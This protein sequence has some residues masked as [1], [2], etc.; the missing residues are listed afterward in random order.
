MLHMTT[1]KVKPYLPKS[2]TKQLLERF[3]QMGAAQ[4]EVAHYIAAD[5]SGG[6]VITET[7][8]AATD[9]VTVLQYADYIEF[10]TKPILA[11][12]DAL[13]HLLK[14]FDVSPPPQ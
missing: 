5:N 10:E 4:G 1:Y 2:E 14:A 13:P 3:M 9:Y 12:A 6:W 7:D 11:V 8:D